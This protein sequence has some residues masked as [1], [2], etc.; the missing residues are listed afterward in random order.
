MQHL[1]DFVHEHTLEERLYLVVDSPEGELELTWQ[2]GAVHDGVWQV[3]RRNVDE[4]PARVH[5]GDLLDHLEAMGADMGAMGRELHALVMTQIAFADVVLRDATQLLGYETVQMVVAGHR[6][7]A[8]Q[9][10]AAVERVTGPARRLELV[11]GGASESSAGTG[12]LT[13]VR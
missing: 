2:R 11:P 9:L 10:K 6:S 5:Y 7:F 13:L 3:K 8:L 4:A 12:N 1:L